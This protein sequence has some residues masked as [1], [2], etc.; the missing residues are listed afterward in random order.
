MLPGPALAQQ[1]VNLV[2]EDDGGL[3]VPRHA[4]QRLH[5]HQSQLSI[6]TI[7]QSQ[8][9]IATI[10]QSQLSIAIINQ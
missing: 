4:E 10:N 1:R 7:N 3:D 8:L 2:N 6:A 5:L 9:S